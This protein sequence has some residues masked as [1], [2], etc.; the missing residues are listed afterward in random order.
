MKMKIIGN[1]QTWLG[2]VTLR[3]PSAPEENNMA[4]HACKDPDAVL[5]N[6]AALAAVLG[7]QAQ[8]LTCANQTHSA[9]FHKVTKKDIGR[10]ALS[11]TDAIPDTDAL[12]TTEPG[13]LLAGFMADCV[14]VLLVNEPA[15]V[16][17]VVHSGWQG[18]VKEITPKLLRHLETEEGCRPEDFIVHIGPALSQEKFQVDQDVCDRFRALGYAGPFI[19]Y[20]EETGKFHIDNKQ[21]VKTQCERAGIITENITVDPTCTFKSGDGF[22]YRENK[23]AGR[24]LAFVVL[25]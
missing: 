4:L 5:G 3:D 9:N 14:P 11:L 12:Y 20:N 8:D 18:T 13:L 24:H 17:A 10:G 7:F 2:G 6:R 22:S 19:Q 23:Q 16:A 25:R 1:D 21:T 15:G